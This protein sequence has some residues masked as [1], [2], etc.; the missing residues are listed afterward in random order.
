MVMQTRSCGLFVRAGHKCALQQCQQV[1]DE[2]LHSLSMYLQGV[3][4]FWYLQ[5]GTAVQF[6]RIPIRAA[7]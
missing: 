2:E 5:R 6:S 1:H 7:L 4:L 3:F